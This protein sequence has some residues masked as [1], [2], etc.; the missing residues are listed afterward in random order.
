MDRHLHGEAEVLSLKG[1]SQFNGERLLVLDAHQ[2][3]LQNSHTSGLA[4]NLPEARR[5]LLAAL[6]DLDWATGGQL[7]ALF[8]QSPSAT[9]NSEFI[10]AYPEATTDSPSVALE[11][12]SIPGIEMF[13]TE[14]LAVA[15]NP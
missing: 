5:W 10:M 9:S 7:C 15:L 1:N 2:N 14:K 8:R 13:T 4:F 12:P 11:E 6:V 3:D